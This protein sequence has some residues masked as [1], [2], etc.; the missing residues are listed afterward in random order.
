MPKTYRPTALTG[1]AGPFI[2]VLYKT[3]NFLKLGPGSWCPFCL[4]QGLVHSK[5]VIKEE[6]ERERMNEQEG[7]AWPDSTLIRAG[8][9]IHLGWS[10]KAGSQAHGLQGSSK[11]WAEVPLC[12]IFPEC[13]NGESRSQ[14]T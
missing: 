3:V 14:E 13:I 9:P 6:P 2:V 8:A 1:H 10:Q 12:S 4:A 7:G 5:S 11:F